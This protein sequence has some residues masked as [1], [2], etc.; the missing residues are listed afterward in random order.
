MASR[1]PKHRGQRVLIA[2]YTSKLLTIFE[3]ACGLT[4]LSRILAWL[5]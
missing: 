4:I 2:G 5:Y 3:I 1:L